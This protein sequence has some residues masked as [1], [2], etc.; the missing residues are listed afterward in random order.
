MAFLEPLIAGL[1]EAGAAEGAAAGAG[2]VSSTGLGGRLGG[3]L[4]DFNDSAVGKI[5]GSVGGHLLSG[6]A[7]DAGSAIGTGKSYEKADIGPMGN[8][9]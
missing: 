5:A 6:A 8:L 7:H 3:A 2:K 4:R 1:G 9:D